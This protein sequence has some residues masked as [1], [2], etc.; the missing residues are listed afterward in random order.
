MLPTTGLFNDCRLGRSFGTAHMS[1]IRMGRRTVRFDTMGPNPK[2]ETVSWHQTSGRR[3]R[4]TLGWPRRLFWNL[5]VM[6]PPSFIDHGS[7]LA[8]GAGGAIRTT[9]RN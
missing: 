6:F 5:L 7:H 2:N 1:Q 9:D 8:I 3:E 4:E